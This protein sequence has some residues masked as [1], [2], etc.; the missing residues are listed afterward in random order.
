M[1]LLLFIDQIEHPRHPPSTTGAHMDIGGSNARTQPPA[2]AGVAPGPRGGAHEV[3]CLAGSPTSPGVSSMALVPSLAG[4][5]PASSHSKGSEETFVDRRFQAKVFLFFPLACSLK[6]CFVRHPACGSQACAGGSSI[7][8]HHLR[9]AVVHLTPLRKPPAST[10]RPL[11]K[12]HA[13]T[14]ESSETPR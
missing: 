7:P 3:L 13:T 5:D 1:R 6:S 9:R 14:L 8:V 10:L 12:P 2:P 4:G 11:K